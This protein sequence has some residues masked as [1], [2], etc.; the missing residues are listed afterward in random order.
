MSGKGAVS[1]TN[2]YFYHGVPCTMSQKCANVLVCILRW[3]DV[4][5]VFWGCGHFFFLQQSFP[6][7]TLSNTTKVSLVMLYISHLLDVKVAACS[8]VVSL[9]RS[10]LE[11]TLHK[12]QQTL[13]KDILLQ[14]RRLHWK[15]ISGS[16]L[17]NFVSM[18]GYPLYPL[19]GLGLLD[20]EPWQSFFFEMAPL[21]CQ[22]LTLK[23]LG[24]ESGACLLGEMTELCMWS[25]ANACHCAQVK[26]SLI[27]VVLW[28]L[29]RR[30]SKAG[31]VHWELSSA[32]ST[33]L[34]R[35]HTCSRSLKSRAA[36]LLSS[37]TLL[38]NRLMVSQPKVGICH[39]VMWG[40]FNTNPARAD[41]LLCLVTA[42]FSTPCPYLYLLLYSA[43][44]WSLS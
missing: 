44:L 28:G 1:S 23:F 14:T 8:R 21:P 22:C 4:M 26:I 31:I 24:F 27:M 18:I 37:D 20:S 15:R 3:C 17:S 41:H 10:M 25:L 30:P 33:V 2:T 5:V 16:E 43:L 6:H 9:G 7:K 34:H 40:R 32:R 39:L 19:G 38:E 36:S 13:F 42:S 35:S 11:F 12:L 29:G